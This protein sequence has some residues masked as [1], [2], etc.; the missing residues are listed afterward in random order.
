MKLYSK[1]HKTKQK[2]KQKTKKL[3]YFK[4]KYGGTNTIKLPFTAWSETE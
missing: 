2:R 1:K 4:N 3:I